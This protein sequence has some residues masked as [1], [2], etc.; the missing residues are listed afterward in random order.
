M[1]KTNFKQY[2]TRW[3]KLGYPKAP[4]YIK[5]CGCGEVSIA[6]CITESS[7]YA[8]QTP[9]TIQPYCKQ[10][11][12]P[13]GDGTY[14]S[15]IPAMMKHYGMTNVKE[16][17]D[18]ASL[19]KE[20]AK[21]GR[22]AIYLMGTKPGGYKNVHWTSCGHFISS[23]DYKYDPET[24]KHK[25][26]LKDSNS[27]A[28]LRNGWHSYE[29]V[30]KNDVVKVWS[31]KLPVTA[32]DK[33][34]AWAK[35][36]ADGGKYKYKKYTGET[37]T[38]QC[39]ICHDLTGKYKG[40]NCIGFA[41]ASWHHGG[42]IPCKC[43]CDVINNGTWET[44]RKKASKDGSKIAQQKL[45]IDDV[46]VI[47]VKG[48]KKIPLS[49]LKKGDIIAYFNGNTYVH[50]ALYLGD[51]KIAD[52]TQHRNPQIKCGAKSYTTMTIKCALRY[53]GK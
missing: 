42:K 45:G 27:T 50:T 18:M 17:A 48:G 9:K 46:K 2:D 10:Y 52:C 53:T 12:A 33:A 6:N 15:G 16:H 13:N 43:S 25:V 49:H 14:W 5:D 3:A 23:T 4:H 34:C 8:S 41:F 21:G 7:K 44:L 20:L 11:A 1:S 47:R 30:L 51:G 24:G 29:A 19:W 28:D 31:G 40:W 26:Y 37:K 36:I 35:K 39:P 22:V 38:H 32:M